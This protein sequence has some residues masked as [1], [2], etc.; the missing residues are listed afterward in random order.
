MY[1]ASHSEVPVRWEYLGDQSRNGVFEDEHW[2]G[3]AGDAEDT[4]PSVAPVGS[5]TTLQKE[6]GT[7]ALRG[8]GGY[9]GSGDDDD[10]KSGNF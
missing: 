8:H 2:R 1:P 6:D 7:A 5:A 10:Q 4:L 3:P 9:G